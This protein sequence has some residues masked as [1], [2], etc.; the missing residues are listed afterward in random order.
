MQECMYFGERAGVF[1]FTKQPVN[2]VMN[3]NV[4]QDV[5]VAEVIGYACYTHVE[6]GSQNWMRL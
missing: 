5:T 6:E 3:L 1:P 2:K 4:E